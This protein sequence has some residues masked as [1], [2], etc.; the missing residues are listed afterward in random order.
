MKQITIKLKIIYRFILIVMLALMCFLN[1]K[2]LNGNYN[3]GYEVKDGATNL[4][5]W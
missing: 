1:A 4:E 5:Q 3:P 2:A